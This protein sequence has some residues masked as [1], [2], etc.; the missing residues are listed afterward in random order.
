VEIDPSTGM[1]INISDLKNY[2][3]IAILDVL[4]HKHIDLDVSYFKNVV[5]TTE[6]LAVFIWN[7]MIPHLGGSLHEVEIYET[8]KNLVR[9][10][11]E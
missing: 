1:V 3:K 5:S 8:P 2:M 11:G 6:N 9:Y 4:D 10:R 7:Q